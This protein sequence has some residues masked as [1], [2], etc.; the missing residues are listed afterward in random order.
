MQPVNCAEDWVSKPSMV[1]GMGV[2][3]GLTFTCEL[4]AFLTIVSK[5][6]I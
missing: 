5:T 2:H 3:I 1:S 4:D 6:M